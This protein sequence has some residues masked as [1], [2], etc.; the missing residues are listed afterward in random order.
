V[1]SRNIGAR[2]AENK[3]NV[4]KENFMVE[5]TFNFTYNVFG[6]E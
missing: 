4:K 6:E 1:I 3:I 2:A 5:I